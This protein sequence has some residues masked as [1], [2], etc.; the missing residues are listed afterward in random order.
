MFVMKFVKDSYW[1]IRNAVVDLLYRVAYIT[2][3]GSAGKPKTS[4]DNSEYSENYPM[5]FIGYKRAGK[6]YELI[7]YSS[8][9]GANILVYDKRRKEDI[10]RMANENN[11]PIAKVYIMGQHLEDVKFVNGVVIDDVDYL[12]ADKLSSFG[13]EYSSVKSMTITGRCQR[14]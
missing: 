5:F 9:I 8:K 10:E 2:E 12:I 6:T 14:I 13:V 7:K 4:M 11:I 1:R 3:P